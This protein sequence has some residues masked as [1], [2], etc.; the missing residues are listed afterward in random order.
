MGWD[1][2]QPMEHL[3]IP[4]P[5]RQNSIVSVRLDFMISRNVNNVN[6]LRR[7]AGAFTLIEL[8]VVIAIIAILAAM[9]LPALAK[10]KERAK[11][12][13][14]LSNLRQ[15]GLSIQM[16]AADSTDAIPRDG[17]GAG[18]PPR[19]TG[20]WCDTATYNGQPTGTP[21]DQFAWFNELPPLVGEKTL[22]TY[23][24]SLNAGRGFSNTK[25]TQYMPF[26]GGQG[27]IWECPSATMSMSTIQSGALAEADSSPTP[28][29]PGGTGFFS[30]VMNIDLKRT[31]GNDF[32]AVMSYPS[33][34]KLT[35]FKQPTATVLMLDQVF[36]PVTEV[37][38]DAPQYNS[39]NPAARQRSF[40]SRHANGGVINFLDGHVGYFKTAYI[41]N[42]PSTDGEQEPLLS[43]VIW[44]APYRGAE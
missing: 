7:K 1:I 44:D 18:D 13:N 16:Y 38:N 41:T 43:D 11:R 26:P 42:N 39:V 20:A 17:Y 25:A 14:C 28:T 2:I 37:V 6:A 34:P 9:L 19:S 3:P 5:P 12:A 4:I 30:Y 32:T 10:A 22:S 36:D 31:S 8:L 24:N 21:A 40:A 29:L 27:K 15:W 23:F 33:M 35:A